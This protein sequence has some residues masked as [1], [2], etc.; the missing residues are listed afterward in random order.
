MN[1]IHRLAL[2]AV[3]SLAAA[4]LNAD[5]TALTR[6]RQGFA[7]ELLRK[8]SSGE[9]PETPPPGVLKLVS[10]PGPLGDMAA[11][12]SPPPADGKRRPAVIWL[13][14]G[15]SNSIGDTAWTPGPEAN[16]QS[17]SAFREAGI[18]TMYPSLR[19]GNR[20]P[21]HIETFYGEVDDVIAATRYL[22]SLDYVDPKRIYL[23]GHST[24]G[25]LALLVAASSD[26]YRAVFAL[27]PVGDVLGYGSDVLPFEVLN[28]KEGQLRAPRRWL[29]AI[30][31]PTFVFEGVQQPGNIGE[32]RSMAVLNRNPLVRFR[33]IPDRDHFSII[34]PLVR[35][36]SGKILRDDGAAVTMDFTKLPAFDAKPK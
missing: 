24:G 19:G 5:E 4:C 1:P 34:A 21:G 18:L 36:L 31:N 7:T 13:F 33:P 29:S 15:F 2:V 26:Q 22:A 10:Y 8:E 20:N 27:G 3:T 35:E 6:A 12:V 11:Y 28:P 25:T 16:D 9:T 17:A 14:G 30:R 32:L 23:G